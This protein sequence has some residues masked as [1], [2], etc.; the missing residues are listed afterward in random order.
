MDI[1]LNVLHVERL[2]MH[3]RLNVDFSLYLWFSNNVNGSWTTSVRQT[4]AR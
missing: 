4:L 2:N 3:L 1:Q